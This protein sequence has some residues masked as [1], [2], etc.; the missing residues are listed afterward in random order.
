MFCYELSLI[1]LRCNTFFSYA[2]NRFLDILFSHENYWTWLD[3][4]LEIEFK[5]EADTNVK[6]N[7][8]IKEIAFLKTLYKIKLIQRNLE[9]ALF[10]A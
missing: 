8:T 2:C 1:C 5:Q 4:S 10:T 3:F 9:A 6:G 7:I